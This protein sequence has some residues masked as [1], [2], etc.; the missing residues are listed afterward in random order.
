MTIKKKKIIVITIIIWSIWILLALSI[1]E[2]FSRDILGKIGY[3]IWSFIGL[4][5]PI[6]GSCMPHPFVRFLAISTGVI[7]VLNMLLTVWLS[8]KYIKCQQED[9]CNH[10]SASLQDDT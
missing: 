8:I 1:N 6:H 2:H 10:L 7:L 4:N 3:V 5:N 9:S